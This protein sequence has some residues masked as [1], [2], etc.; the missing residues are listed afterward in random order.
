LPTI[1]GS[2]QYLRFDLVVV[3][4]QHEGARVD[5]VASLRPDMLSMLGRTLVALGVE[6]KEIEIETK[7]DEMGET[8]VVEPDLVGTRAV[9]SV[10]HRE[11][12]SQ[13][14]VRVRDLKAA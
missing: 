8:V 3:G 13:T 5:T 9:A 6:G 12:G 4:G 11:V 1:D 10:I 2:N 7:V 14:Y